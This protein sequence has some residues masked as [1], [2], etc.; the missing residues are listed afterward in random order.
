MAEEAEFL[1]DQLGLG[2]AAL[3]D[4][5]GQVLKMVETMN[6][7]VAMSAEVAEKLKEELEEAGQAV[8]A[9]VEAAAAGAG[10]AISTGLAEGM[11]GAAPEAAAGVRTVTEDV[12][13]TIGAAGSDMIAAGYNLADRPGAGHP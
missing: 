4:F 6:I 5:V 11:A 13:T 12:T 1:F 2:D 10:A 3:E 7:P 8:P 9:A